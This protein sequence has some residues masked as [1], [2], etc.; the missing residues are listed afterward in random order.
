MC[1]GV[2]TTLLPLLVQYDDDDE[3]EEEETR[4]LLQRVSD[5]VWMMPLPCVT[6]TGPPLRRYVDVRDVSVAQSAYAQ[7]SLVL[8]S[9]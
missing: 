5:E 2:L 3:D 6:T 7:G 4:A 8:F 9:E 1:Q